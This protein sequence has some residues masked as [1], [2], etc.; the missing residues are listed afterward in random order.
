MYLPLPQIASS[1][2]TE[3]TQVMPVSYPHLGQRPVPDSG[4]QG[5]PLCLFSPLGYEPLE[6]RGVA[7]ASICLSIQH[8]VW[9]LVSP[10]RCLL[11]NYMGALAYGYK[12]NH[13]YVDLTTRKRKFRL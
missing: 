4:G 8:R 12:S 6:A 1:W 11:N 9:H 7:Y 3:V 10:E 5:S 2:V 13:F